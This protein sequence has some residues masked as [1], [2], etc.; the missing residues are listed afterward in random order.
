MGQI[1]KALLYENLEFSNKECGVWREMWGGGV[2]GA[3][4]AQRKEGRKELGRRGRGKTGILRGKGERGAV[5]AAGK[6]MQRRWQTHGGACAASA[7]P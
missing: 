2:G 1:I 3:P 4:E 5:G 6:T 7:T